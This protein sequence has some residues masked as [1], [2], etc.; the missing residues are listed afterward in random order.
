MI[1]K[2]LISILPS[3]LIF[4]IPFSISAEG[5]IGTLDQ[6]TATTSPY[7][8][9]TQT[10][11]NTPLKLTGLSSLSP[12]CVSS[13]GIATTTGCLSITS[14]TGSGQAGMMT[15]WL[16]SIV[17]TSTSTIVGATVHA[18]STAT[19]TFQGGIVAN[20]LNTSSTTAS[21]TFSN[22]INLN[23][24][25]FAISGVCVGAGGASLSGGSSNTLM[26]WI[27]ATTAGAT[28]S[29]T[30][31]YITATTTSTSTL[32]R[33]SSTGVS[34][35]WLCLPGDCRSVWPSGAPAGST[36]DIQLNT[37]GAFS[38]DTG[39]FYY[40]KT[41]HRFAVG[42]N[43]PDAQGHF[44]ATS[45]DLNPPAFSLGIQGGYTSTY[46]TGDT[47]TYRAYCYASFNNLYYSASYIEHSIGIGSDGDTPSIEMG[48]GCT[49]DGTVILRDVNAG[50]YNTATIFAGTS[51]TFIDDNSQPWSGSTTV[52]PNSASVDTR[53]NYNNAGAYS[54]LHTTSN[55]HVGGNLDVTGTSA[56]TG[57]S[58]FT[59]DVQANGNVRLGPTPN[60]TSAPFSVVTNAS[61]GEKR[62][63]FF[64]GKQNTERIEFTLSN[65]GDGAWPDNFIS[66]MNHGSAYGSNYYTD[67][68]AGSSIFLLQGSSA[69]QM[70]FDT[71]SATQPINFWVG[72]NKKLD[73]TSAGVNITAPLA[74][75]GTL[76]TSGQIPI[77]D[78]SS[79]PVWTTPSYLSGTVAIANGGTNSTSI[80]SRSLLW[81]N[82]T[83][84]T[85]TSSIVTVGSLIGTTTATSSF[86]G[87]VSANTFS[88]T[89][90]TASSTFANGINLTKGCFAISGVCIGG[91]SASLSGGSPNTFAYWSS[92][93]T[94]SATG[95]PTVTAIIATSTTAT[96]TF[97]G[98]LNVGPIFDTSSTGASST[99]PLGNTV[100]NVDGSGN[101]RG[102][103]VVAAHG[104]TATLAT[105]GVNTFQSR[106]TTAS[107]TATQSG[108]DLYFMGARGY[109]TSNYGASSKVAI[110]EQ[111]SQA[112]TDANQGTQ[113]TFEVTPNNSTTRAEVG[114]FDN[115][116]KLGIG[117]STPLSTLTINQKSS[118]DGIRLVGTSVGGANLGTGFIVSLGYNAIDNKQLWLG[119]PDYLGNSSKAFVRYVSNTGVTYVDSVLGDNSNY[120]P[121]GFGAVGGSKTIIGSDFTITQPGS[122]LWVNGNT[123]IGADWKANAAPTNG[124]LVEGNVGIGTSSPYTKL[125]VEG[126]AA[127]G[128]KVGVIAKA[129]YATSTA[130]TIADTTI[131]NTAASSTLFTGATWPNRTYK[132]NTLRVN[133]QIC[134]QAS[135]T[136]NT[137]G[138]TPSAIARI[139]LGT[140]SATTT[141]GQVTTTGL[142]SGA[143]SL[144]FD[145]AGCVTI[146][147]LGSSGTVL[148]NATLDYATAVGTN[149]RDVIRGPV[150]TIDT[151]VDQTFDLTV[152]F[153]TASASEGATITQ[154][155]SGLR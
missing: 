147:S 32:P 106:G 154:A 125:S 20:I 29:P 4:L 34:T 102:T 128:G 136:Y 12:L 33:L 124:L 65:S 64:E 72:N 10:I 105:A 36:G 99:L 89:S 142:A 3:L 55:V 21:S 126:D 129:F 7:D 116:G 90:T 113:I 35:S 2:T 91:G 121:I 78:G 75:N 28:S 73:L 122:Q 80:P 86:T 139:V 37:S 88:A 42:T 67:H 50:G 114:R 6:F 69:Y 49:G 132:A 95:T 84:I 94:L 53:I 85:A 123:T 46:S 19:S 62:V 27:N 143:T 57:A 14:V 31:N 1:K 44:Y 98:F 133:S 60:D 144:A 48:S 117:T 59:G 5:N 24:G 155:Y 56:F 138:I 38:A 134:F 25:C 87:G 131:V 92:P 22:G 140:G 115:A 15:S 8:A 77:S 23:K 148:T 43:A 70:S 120:G 127:I 13:L 150:T 135:G 93:T 112:W 40:D 41:N 45:T 104:S 119:D 39:I 74:F 9:I 58:T 52:I 47:V 97:A 11:S 96:S 130:V 81:F 145:A 83:S 76:G 100:F 17:V 103:I 111:A 152:Q 82:G 68:D 149:K 18:T 146:R 51:G 109:G 108:D 151:T 153:D 63:G 26:Y 110:R 141:I 30:V 107:P 54:G 66:I 71:Y 118:T 79:N 61:G 101:L 137:T 16:T